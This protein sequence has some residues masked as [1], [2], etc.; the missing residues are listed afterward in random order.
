MTHTGAARVRL[1]THM[2][3]L[4]PGTRKGDLPRETPWLLTT[5]QEEAHV[6][7][8]N[9]TCRTVTRERKPVLPQGGVQRGT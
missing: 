1:R 7:C 6:P 5:E 9:R 2:S 3:G 8:G 4:D